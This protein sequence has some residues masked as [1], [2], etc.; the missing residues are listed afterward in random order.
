MPGAGTT[1]MEFMSQ[2]AA[3]SKRTPTVRV[4]GHSLGGAL[5]PIV[6]LW[7]EDTVGSKGSMPK[8]TQVQAD[9]SAGFTPGMHYVVVFFSYIT[10]LFLPLS[11]VRVF[12]LVS[13]SYSRPSGRKKHV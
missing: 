10:L 9:P 8:G 7:F 5:A 4:A 13:L 12:F 6:A 3:K 1:I 2:N 11:A